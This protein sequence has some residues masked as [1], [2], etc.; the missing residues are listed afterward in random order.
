MVAVLNTLIEVDAQ[1]VAWIAGANT[2]VVE[3]VLDKLAYG[4]SPEE[5]H[6]QHPHLSMAQIHAALSYYYDHQAE[7]DADIER[8]N[9]Y[10]EEM[11]ALQND[12][13]TREE[14]LRRREAR[15]KQQ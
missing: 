14:L 3:V 10:V 11:R 2:K 15:E 1:G 4:W 7:I 13:F 12:P 5:M 8:R 6:R 9:R